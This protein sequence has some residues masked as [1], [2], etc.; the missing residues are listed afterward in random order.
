MLRDILKLYLI[1]NRNKKISD[2]EFLDLIEQAILGGVTSIQLREKNLEFEKF[3]NL[4]TQ[5]KEITEKYNIPLFIND[6]LVIAKKISAYG[7]H[8]GQSD[9]SLQNAREYLGTNF[10]IGISINNLTQ[11]CDKQNEYADY[12][13]IGPIFPT[14][15]KTDAENPIGIEAISLLTRNKSKPM[16]AIGGITLD[17]IHTLMNSELDGFAISSAIFNHKNS[18]FKANKFI[19]IIKKL[20]K[21]K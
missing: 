4:A 21:Y 3:L 16:I 17:N 15:T 10:I 5:C 9:S 20:M 6:N 13:S 1:T 2:I 12:L 19:L 18:I 11:L 14:N 8:V 7:V